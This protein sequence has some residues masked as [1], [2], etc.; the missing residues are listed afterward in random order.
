MKPGKLEAVLASALLLLA[1]CAAAPLA[2]NE[3]LENA[4][5]TYRSVAADSQV[6]LRAPT[7]LSLA[8]RALAQAEKSWRDRAPADLVAHQAYLAQQR[9]RIAM[10][11]AQ[12][13]KSEAAVAVSG[14]QR[15]RVL[16]QAREHEAQSAKAQARAAELRAEQSRVE[17]E[18]R[19]DELARSRALQERPAGSADMTRDLSSLK[20]QIGGLKSEQTERGWVLTLHN[21]ALFDT[22]S[23]TLKPLARRAMDSLAAFMNRYPEREIA[24]EGFTD[25]TGTNEA[26]RRLSESRAAAV[27]SALVARGIEPSR[28]DSRGYGPAF[29]VASNET[30]TGRQQNRRVEIVINPS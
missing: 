4:R 11:T 20:A 27:K 6:Q 10:N 22:G 28:I 3:S 1:G 2:N 7:E 5:S 30:P 23:S 14:E 15:N 21:D 12:Y 18:T 29:P 9:A 19:A 13:R 26:N 17:A 16:L 24:I 25:S 8:E